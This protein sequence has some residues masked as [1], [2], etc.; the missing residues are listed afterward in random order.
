M[1][2]LIHFIY[3]LGTLLK[4]ITQYRESETKR[5]Q[6]TAFMIRQARNICCLLLTLSSS[7]IHT[8]KNETPSLQHIYTRSSYIYITLAD[9]G[10][11]LIYCSTL[12][13]QLAIRTYI[14]ISFRGTSWL[15]LSQLA[16]K[17]LCPYCNHQLATSLLNPQFIFYFQYLLLCQL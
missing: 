6:E 16:S 9:C 7:Y 15:A 3:L 8:C 1:E 10:I 5:K 17:L 11:L 2:G 13:T 12:I 14:A 4:V